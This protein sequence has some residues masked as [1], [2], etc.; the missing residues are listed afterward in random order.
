VVLP[1]NQ[2]AMRILTIHK[3]KGLE[4]KV[5]ILPFLSWE[6][7]HRPSKQP[8]LW[9][10]PMV[11]PFCRLGIVPVRYNKDLADTIFAE[12]YRS[13][14]YSVFIDNINLLY[15]AM[16]RAKDA[17]FGFSVQSVKSEST[18]A[19]VLRNAIALDIQGSFENILNLNQFYKKD[20]R[21]FEFG[22]IPENRREG[23]DNSSMTSDFYN[24]SRKLE[25]L[26][27][28]LHGENYFSSDTAEVRKK[29][30]YGKL[31]HE[32]FEGIYTSGDISDAIR[33][34]VLE[35]KL[36]E[37]DSVEMG[38]RIKSL[39]NDPGV[40][41]WFMEGN[42]VLTEASILLPSGTMKRPDRVILRDGKA[43]IV[44]FK[45]GEE[46]PHYA[47]QVDQYRRLMADMGYENIDA[48]IWYV[49]KNQIVTV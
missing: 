42:K 31:M 22:E 24:V 33:K 14:K 27:L 3:S 9:A 5:V 34:S 25:S 36:P 1:G 6:L 23:N 40:S 28:K 46:N 18:I 39:I 16:T 2:N 8:V 37:N 15:V 32:I 44:D 49:D 7:D 20:K 38:K 26:K 30:N 45:F 4:F 47:N 41:D 29:I 17:I 12:E 11:P 21:I 35:G 13:E 48:F 19:G 10:K 43:I